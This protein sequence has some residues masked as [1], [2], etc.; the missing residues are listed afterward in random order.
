VQ[1]VTVIEKAKI[2]D[3]GPLRKLE[4]ECFPLDA[5]PLIDLITMLLLP[6]TIR[7]KAEHKG[8]LIGFVGGDIRRAHQTGWITTLAVLPEYRRLG[9][10]EALLRAGEQALRMPLVK[11]S[12]RRTNL[13]AQ[14][15]YL[16]NGYHKVETWRRYY[17]GGE[18]A[19]VMEKDM[20]AFK[21]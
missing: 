3:L 6:G 9:I 19:I 4:K 15:L 5:W 11:L 18:D 8:R 20:P 13:E 2:N 12:V 21:L 7:I 17:E 14:L 1:L 16:K 10:G